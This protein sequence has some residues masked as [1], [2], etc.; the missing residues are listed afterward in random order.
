MLA[1]CLIALFTFVALAVDVGM[2]AVSRTQC[3]QA[4]DLAALIGA[5]TINNKPGVVDSN[6]ANALADA[7]VAIIGGTTSTGKT[8]PPNYNLS[9][10]LIDPQVT[11]IRAGQY[12]YDT[13][14]Q[15]FAVTYPSSIATGQSWTAVE[16]VIT[17]S[18]PTYF[19]RVFGVSSMPSGARSVA[20]H[21][22][23]DMALVL[24]MTGS[25]GYSSLT[26]IY[27]GLNDPNAVWPAF[28]HYQRYSGYATNALGASESDPS[29]G[30]RPNPFQ[31]MGTRVAAPYVYAPA[32]LSIETQNGKPIIKDFYF[33]YTAANMA[34]PSV[35]VTAPTINADGTNNL[36]NA[37]QRWNP[38]E[39]GADPSNNIGPTRDYTGYDS[40][41]NGS[42]SSPKGPTPAP[43]NFKDQTD[44]PIPFVG[45]KFPRK[46]GSTATGTWDPTNATGA[47][48]NAAEYL[49]W[50]A[51][52]SSG[53]SLS[54]TLLPTTGGPNWTTGTG[55][56]LVPNQTSPAGANFRDALWERYGYDMDVNDY[57]T[58][59]TA[60]WDP[61]FDW[62][63]KANSGAGGW[64][65]VRAA[66]PTNTY[67]PSVTDGKFKGYTMGPQYWGKTFFMWPADPRWGNPDG[68]QSANVNSASTLAAPLGSG[69]LPASPSTTN[70]VKDTNGNYICD[71]RR[72][73]FLD[74][75]GN[76]YNPQ[77]DA[78]TVTPGTQ[79]INEE[80]F[81]NGT[82]ATLRSPTGNWQT[83]YPAILAWIKSP[84]QVL[85]PNLRAG[86]VLYYSS[87]PNDVT[88]TGSD[89]ADVQADKVFWKTYI[90]YVLSTGSL[91]GT[92]PMGWPEGVAPS[93]DQTGLVNFD[94]DSS[95]ALAADPKPYMNYVD[96]P[97]RPR[98]HFWFG[99]MTM[100]TFLSDFNMWAGTT[101]Q[102][103]SWQLKAGVNSA[104]DDIRNNHPNDYVGLAYFSNSD[105]HSIIVATGQDWFTLKNAL[106]FPRSIL[107]TLTSSTSTV[108]WR[109]YDA[110]N[111]LQS[112]RGN[113]PNAQGS[114]DPVSGLTMAFN[115]LSPSQY[116]NTDPTR[117]GRRGATKIVIFETDGIPNSTQ[118]YN[119][120]KYGYDSYYTFG[121]STPNTDPKGAAY[122]TVDQIRK[123]AATV[124]TAGTDSGLSLPNAPSRVYSIGFG[125]IFST[126]AGPTAEAFLLTVQ[127]HG[128]TS[129]PTATNMP[130]TQIITGPYQTRIDNLRIALQTICQSGVQVT[131]IE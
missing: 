116:V 33:A 31:Q 51:K 7:R 40:T 128:G 71:W 122:D 100:L 48:I 127:Q 89:S 123:P 59:R 14:N 63:K 82:G 13:T 129:P 104:L 23:R 60:T 95:G 34:D 72:R 49:G 39:T 121:G 120:Q 36:K 2:L 75:N 20:V 105:Y 84:P 17:T 85:P 77:N 50:V 131:L 110:T 35:A 76:T 103:Q 3:Q 55:R 118:P 106:F 74:R 28:S 126:T 8:V 19:M 62:D 119:F 12:S 94:I 53:S 9:S 98:M 27:T 124:Q 56:T 96:N 30:N 5:R 6:R 25:M 117:R 80:M 112:T 67:R 47:A 45:D 79:S 44:T 68:W 111:G 42:E 52:Y 18:Q 87:I 125:D 22:P 83:N 78:D 41:N 29:V 73:F 97:S 65:H 69:V 10:A 57:I 4:A 38:P 26:N 109:P 99:P 113:I 70:P 11:S 108:E 81:T 91:A 61:R 37:F 43:D 64:T 32:N 16:V 1:C 24:D 86:R 21:R 102:A 130:P 92:E 90:D 88:V 93:I 58:N 101:H 107:P 54:T 15:V 66:N 46:Y 114:T 115:I